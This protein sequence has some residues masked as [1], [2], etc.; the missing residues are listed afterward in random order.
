MQIISLT[1]H[2]ADLSAQQ[3]FYVKKLGFAQN[4]YT[5]DELSV[6]SGKTELKF[7]F[8]SE[9]PYYHYCFLVPNN[10]LE[11]ALNWI[12]EKTEV[13]KIDGEYMVES[14]SEWEANSIYFYDGNRNIIEF[15]AHFN[16]DN[17]SDKKFSAESVISVNE[18]GCPSTDISGLNN[19]L[20]QEIGTQF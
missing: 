4:H 19:W 16:L 3:I 15:I 8:S 2:S 7:K 6:Q 14:N 13:I 11:E 1:L 12:K 17:G 18:I 10:K 5:D 9:Q 20:A